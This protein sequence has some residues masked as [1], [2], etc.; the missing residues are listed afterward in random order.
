[1]TDTH[2]IS[3]QRLLLFFGLAGYII[4]VIYNLGYTELDGEEPRRALVSIEMLESGNFIVPTLYGW[5]YYN[6]PPLFNWVLCGFIFIFQTAQEAVVRLPSLFALL[7]WA[8]IHYTVS[9]KFIARSIA[10][11]STIIFL[12]CG[13]L[14]FYG[15]QNGGE[16]D[17]FYG[18]LTYLQVIAILY[19]FHSKKWLELFLVSYLF[20][21]L[22][23]LTKAFPSVAFQGFTLVAF[24][25][26][27]RSIRFI[28]SWQHFAGILLF[29]VVTGSYFF[30]YNKYGS[31]EIYLINL[32]S[33]AVQ[34]TPVGNETGGFL[35]NLYLYPQRILVGLLPWSLLFVLIF[36]KPKPAFWS[37]PFLKYSI[38]FL[39]S[40][41]WLYWF[42]GVVKLRYSYIFFP[43]ISLFIAVIYQ[44]YL[45][46]YNWLKLYRIAGFAFLVLW[47]ATI[48]IPIYFPVNWWLYML[49]VLIV[50]TYTI[51]Y[52][53]Q[54]HNL[55]FVFGLGIIVARL[56]YAMVFLPVINDSRTSTSYRAPMKKVHELNPD[57]SL[58]FYGIPDTLSIQ[59]DVKIG[60]T[61][62]K[63]ILVPPEIFKQVPYYYYL[64]SGT[65]VRYDTALSNSQLAFSYKPF[66][67]DSVK[68]PVFSFFDSRMTHDF[69]LFYKDQ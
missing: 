14:Y 11:L 46:K 10:F 2:S 65:P 34:K 50:A 58:I 56:T 36:K 21:A 42:F 28:F 13:E 45:E 62:A 25:I 23:F 7:A 16:L 9:K 19:F 15:L 27:S 40:N 12:T 55:V 35:K 51:W 61:K 30:I 69:L 53:K 26:Y 37:N 66:L 3:Q 5:D 64:Y 32:L 20:C 49:T 52:Y 41:M 60:K 1:M 4:S 29:L 31:A 68:K 48:L 63:N 54:K 67:E 8:L 6:K 24:A 47:V 22:G 44:H 57:K 59:A 43:F 17:I 33:E 38:L 39:V 18:L